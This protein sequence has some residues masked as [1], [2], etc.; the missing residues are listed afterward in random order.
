MII[1]HFI[2]WLHYYHAAR[3]FCVKR[4]VLTFCWVCVSLCL[5]VCVCLCIHVCVAIWSQL[6]LLIFFSLSVATCDLDADRVA[7]YDV[8]HAF[9]GE[10]SHPFPPFSTPLL[11]LCR[12]QRHFPNH[13]SHFQHTTPLHI[14]SRLC[15]VINVHGSAYMNHHVPQHTH[16]HAYA[17]MHT[18]AHIH[19]LLVLMVLM[20]LGIWWW[21]W[22]WWQLWVERWFADQRW[23]LLLLWWWRWWWTES[24]ARFIRGRLGCYPLSHTHS[25][26]PCVHTHLITPHVTTTD[27][28]N[29]DVWNGENICE[30]RVCDVNDM[31]DG[32][33]SV[34]E[35]VTFKYTDKRTTVSHW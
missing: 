27:D 22:W 10:S 15:T 19:G 24:I 25:H 14:T 29:D 17:H 8:A 23:W 20:G 1:G 12:H 4:L 21:C 34:C 9:A 30:C 32:V 11:P 7:M 31:S 16:I 35:C 5:C 13:P 33:N 6:R 3:H 26:T 18:H 2:G 28:D